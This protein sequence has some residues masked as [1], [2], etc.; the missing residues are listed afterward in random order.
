VGGVGIN[1]EI[2]T[3]TDTI[4]IENARET[5]LSGVTAGTYG[6]AT[7]MPRFTV[8][9]RGRIT[10]VTPVA[11]PSE[12]QT[13][14]YDSAARELTLSDGNTVDLSSLYN[15]VTA[16][17]HIAV[18]GQTNIVAER[19]NDTL[20]FVG[21]VGV[22]ITTDPGSDRIIISATGS[23]AAN[24]SGSSIAD[25]ADV[26]PLGSIQNGQALVWNSTNSR[27]EPGT[28]ASSGGTTY[29]AGD[30]IIIGSNVVA[31]DNTV[32]RTTG[33]QTIAGQKT[34]DGGAI[35]NSGIVL[36][37]EGD[38]LDLSSLLTEVDSGTVRTNITVTHND[39]NSANA[40]LN[41]ELNISAQ[42]DGASTINIDADNVNINNISYPSADGSAG[43]ALITDGAGNLT[44]GT[45]ASA[46]G[47]ADVQAYLNA[48]GYATQSAVI[49]AVTDSAPTTLD[50]LNELAAAL[51]DDPNFATTITNQIATKANAS[52]LATV[53]T[54]GDYTDLSNKPVLALSGSNIS[55]DGTTLDL[56]GVGAVGAKGDTGATGAQGPAGND[57][58]SVATAT[59]SSG[60]LIITLSN[61]QTVNAG[62][63]VGPQGIQ[64]L[65]GI[66]GIQGATGPQGN[67]GPAGPQGVQGD[68]GND[69]LTVTGATISTNNLV[70]TL[71][72]SSTLN[73]GNVRGP[74]GPAGPAG[75]QGDGDAGISTATVNGSGNLIVTLN[76]ATTIDAGNVK[77]DVGDT[78]PQ[79]VS[80]A[81]TTLVGTNLVVNYSNTS[82]VDLGNIQGPQGDQGVKGDTGD[83]GP[84]G[85]QG[86]TGATGAQGPQGPAGSD[87][88]QLTDFSVSTGSASGSGSLS[89]ASGTGVFTFTPP[90]LSSYLTSETDN[91]TFSLAG[92][93]IT[94]SGSGS[95][96]D[97]TSALGS[98]SGGG[99]SGIADLSGNVIS[100]LGDVSNS[101]PTDGQ[102]LVWDNANSTWKP[103]TVASSGGIALT[104]LSGGTGVDYDNTTGEIA[105]AGSGVSA[106]TYGSSTLV[107]RITVDATGRI[108]GVTTQAVSG[109][110]GGGGSGATVERFK[111]NYTSS[112]ALNNTTDLTSG[113][114][115]VSI[116]SAAG[117]DVTINFNGYNFPPAQ[118][119]IYGYVYAS[120]KYTITPF[121][122]TIGLRE[123]A[124]GGSTGSPTLFNGASTPS[125][126][127]RLREAETGASRSFGTVT[128]AW[129]QFVMYD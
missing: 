41:A 114:A 82:T 3:V 84:A 54:S 25:L 13:L 42:A 78:G 66:Q 109:G 51:G 99:G 97:L 91:Q 76:D 59:V 106:G 118:I 20:T 16:F 101:A 2:D 19:E 111:L 22:N 119:L 61:A 46:F 69:G 120:N 80:I 86:A 17:T 115:S 38:N 40:S 113:I 14:A 68:P 110:G 37:P 1:L 81:S 65:Q 33:N 55:L 21:G 8:D 49:A 107:P 24:I 125:I 32:V 95:T 94:I 88:V 44:F 89:Y 62:N 53:A 79:G 23:S 72:D 67:V 100:D 63:V 104:D 105:L 85:S 77:G 28:V 35:F 5:E 58:V 128:H 43:Q 60:D 48:Q 73:A 15:D 64:G 30:G 75:P 29:T 90:D 71:S 45:V 96:V 10:D 126:K 123:I 112:G 117:G 127:L 31:V 56:S 34:F 83:T 12:I 121:E 108:T 103:G 122:S 6:N 36:N 98:V 57:G 27:F 4:T 87:G 93:V 26:S 52:S 116:D 129:I 50:T 124:G 92:N 18:A 102:A 39:V 70:L 47:N 74:V 9:N 11:V 7:T